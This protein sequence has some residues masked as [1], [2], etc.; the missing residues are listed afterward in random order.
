M[1]PP[2]HFGVAFAA[3]STKS[4]AP[5]WI[6]MIASELLD[7]LSF[8]FEAIGLERFAIS[9]TTLR[10]G[11][12]IIKPGSIPWSHSLLMSVVWSTLAA[13]IVYLIYREEKTSLVVGLVVF[14]HWVLDFIVHPPDL[15]LLLKNSP[16]VGLGTWSSGPG[17]I[18][19]IALELL[20]LSGGVVLYANSKKCSKALPQ[21]KQ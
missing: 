19:S 8:S 9:R 6:M 21:L 7:L 10:E 13:G 11:V 12:Q 16:Q 2:G 14:S 4:T 20:L 15:Y 18:A 5:L 1:G 3:K 17:L